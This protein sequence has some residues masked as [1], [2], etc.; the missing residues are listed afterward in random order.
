MD[1][2]HGPA[3]YREISARTLLRD[4][5]CT[6]AWFVGRYGMNLYR[7][8]E[9]AC[10]YCDGR[11][12]RYAVDGRF[13]RDI[14]VKINA[15]ALL[16]AELSRARAPGFLFVGGGVCDAYQPAEARYGLARR[17][18]ELALEHARPL[19]VLTKAALVERDMDLLTESARLR[20][21]ILSLSIQTVDEELRA[22]YEPGAAPIA[23]RWELLRRARAAGLATGVMA[24]PVLPGLSDAPE[25]IDALVAA[26]AA[27]GVDFLLHGGLTLRPGVQKEH[28]LAAVAEHRPELVAQVRRLYERQERSGV[29]D[30]GYYRLVD[31]AF[32]RA[33]RR[34]GLP[35]RMPHRLFAGQLSLAAE[36]A[37]LL[38]H[39]AWAAGGEGGGGARALGRAG[40]ALQRWARDRQRGSARLGPGDLED[41]LRQRIHDG[42]LASVPG[43][44]DAVLRALRG[45][46]AE[47]P[48]RRSPAPRQ[49][50]LL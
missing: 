9:H 17:A 16:A 32:R 15:P 12:E 4:S 10:A 44:T 13:D 31:Q 27:A 20:P 29:G 45:L 30:S 28:Y 5:G 18:L 25:Q 49:L 26:A 8:C 19:H 3:R 47:L 2:R 48:D 1:E 22:R 38:E 7:G 50:R 36:L 35:G 39:R 21:T 11:A 23:A 37:V 14:A 6:D 40:W 24:M 34:H 41:E 42:S 43:V 33:L 46:L